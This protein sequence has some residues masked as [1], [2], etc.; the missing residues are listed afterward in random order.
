M[1]AVG[2]V[3]VIVGVVE[4]DSAEATKWEV[5]AA[6]GGGDDGGD[7]GRSVG[8]GGVEG[9]APGGRS[10]PSGTVILDALRISF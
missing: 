1:G 3:E 8:A 4:S 5:V 2:E 7:G 9:G 6:V 10:D